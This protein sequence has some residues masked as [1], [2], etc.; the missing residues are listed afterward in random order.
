LTGG[1]SVAKYNTFHTN[2]TTVPYG[3]EY[4][5]KWQMFQKDLQQ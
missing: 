1:V 4:R 3:T 5:T 2:T